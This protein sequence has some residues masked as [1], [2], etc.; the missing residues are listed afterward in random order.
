MLV[1]SQSTLGCIIFVVDGPTITNIM[2]GAGYEGETAIGTF[3]VDSNPPVTSDNITIMPDRQPAPTI[4]VDGSTVSVTFET[5]ERSDAKSY[6]VTVKN[7]AINTTDSI[8]LSIDV[9]CEY[10]VFKL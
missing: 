7:E 4:S 10:S 2:D 8:T 3:S 6:T 9:Y 5:L 1:V